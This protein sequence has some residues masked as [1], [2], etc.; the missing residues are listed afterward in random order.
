MP[1][2]STHVDKSYAA[3]YLISLSVS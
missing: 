2:N 1:T 3:G